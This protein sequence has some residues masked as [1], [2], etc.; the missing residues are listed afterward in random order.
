MKAW[1]DQAK[2]FIGLWV[3]AGL[4][5]LGINGRAL[6]SLLD[7]PLAGHSSGVRLADRGFQQYR[8]LLSAKAEKISS[9]MAHLVQ[10]FTASAPTVEHALAVEQ[11]QAPVKETRRVKL[12]TVTLPVLTGI[13]TS[14]SAAGQT[15]R[16]A[17]LDSGVYSEGEQLQNFTIRQ[18]S[19]D[20]ILL[21]RGQQTWFL[22]RPDIGYS[23]S[24]R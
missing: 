2:A 4:I 18:I 20:G 14:R 9:G 19:A 21:A 17:V 8:Q 23:L 6:L 22:E 15:H 11:K 3:I 1:G 16:V 24:Q 10:R 12:P 5:V 7:E 13:V